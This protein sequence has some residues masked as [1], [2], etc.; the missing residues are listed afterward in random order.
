MIGTETR[1][2]QADLARI[3]SLVET[4]GWAAA[5]RVI[6]AVSGIDRRPLLHL[7]TPRE[8]ATL[9]VALAVMVEHGEAAT[10]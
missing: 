5:R 4:V 2:S 7:L 6:A 3:E 10:G 9:K 1:V 8:A